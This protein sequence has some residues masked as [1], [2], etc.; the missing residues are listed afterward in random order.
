MNKII[1]QSTE[2]SNANKLLHW[3]TNWQKWHTTDASGKTAAKKVW[4]DQEGSSFKAALLSGPPGTK[5]PKDDYH[6]C[7]NLFSLKHCL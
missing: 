1:G 3:L 5:C 2:K 6:I 4:N 7:F